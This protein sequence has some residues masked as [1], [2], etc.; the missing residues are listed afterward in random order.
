MP[1]DLV[2]LPDLDQISQ[3]NPAWFFQVLETPEA[4]EVLNRSPDYLKLMRH[5]GTGPAYLKIGSKVQY[6]RRDLFAWMFAG[7][8]RSTRIVA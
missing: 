3:N 4:A 7:K 8:R 6:V 1:S 5:R 2:C